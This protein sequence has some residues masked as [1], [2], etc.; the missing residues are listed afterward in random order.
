MSLH[1]GKIRALSVVII[2]K[3]NRVLVSPGYDSVKDAH[4]YRLVGGG[5]EFGE[6][7]V[8]ALKRELQEE[9]AA[10][11]INIRLLDIRENIFT[12]NGENGHE[13]GFIYEAEF[14]DRAN[15]K[16]EKFQILD[17]HPDNFAIWAEINEKNAEIVFPSGSGAL[18]L[19]R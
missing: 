12:Y 7:S 17:G 10:E 18:I 2:K 9:L 3:D 1:A 16:K 13:I 5:I 11:L 19:K 4:F 8:E 6:T 14:K 15:Y